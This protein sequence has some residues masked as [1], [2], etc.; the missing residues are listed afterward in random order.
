MSQVEPEGTSELPA[1]SR[2]LFVEKVRLSN[3]ACQAGDYCTA[4]ALYTDALALDPA[5]HILYSNRY[6]LIDSGSGSPLQTIII[7]VVLQVSRKIEAGTIF[8]SFTGCHKSQRVVSHV[9]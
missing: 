7:I 9:A 5:N 4:V 1:A 3:A 2:S 8:S 6:W